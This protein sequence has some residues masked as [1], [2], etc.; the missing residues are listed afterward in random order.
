MNRVSQ[1]AV[2]AVLCVS[3]NASRITFEESCIDNYRKIPIAFDGHINLRE[4]IIRTKLGGGRSCSAPT[5]ALIANMY[6]PL[7]IHIL[8]SLGHCQH[9]AFACTIELWSFWLEQRSLSIERTFPQLKALTR[10]S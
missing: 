8:P 10:N 4:T 3:V 2:D 7:P 1:G 6:L 5:S 9:A